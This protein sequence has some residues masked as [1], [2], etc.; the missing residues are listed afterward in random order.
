MMSWV[1]FVL[2][3]FF[4]LLSFQYI[5]LSANI[6]LYAFQNFYANM[7]F[8]RE[9]C[10]SLSENMLIQY[11]W[12]KMHQVNIRERVRERDTERAGDYVEAFFSALRSKNTYWA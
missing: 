7:Y 11:L 2:A 3:F 9:Q 1:L 4:S 12:I 8:L 10:E 6:L 5:I